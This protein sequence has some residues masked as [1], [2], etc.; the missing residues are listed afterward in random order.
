MWGPIVEK[1]ESRLSMW[2]RQ[3]VCLGG[4]VNSNQTSVV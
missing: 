2:K 3:Y 1:L 4:R